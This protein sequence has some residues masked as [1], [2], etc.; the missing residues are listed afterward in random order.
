MLCGNP[1]KGCL[2]RGDRAILGLELQPIA[3][4]PT[5]NVSFPPRIFT[6][7]LS[8]LIHEQQTLQSG[9]HEHFLAAIVSSLSPTGRDPASP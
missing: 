1:E 3:V 4:P 5:A 7:E 8:T 6:L 9:L 2:P